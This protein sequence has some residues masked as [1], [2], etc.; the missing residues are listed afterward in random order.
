MIL[1]FFLGLHKQQC[2]GQ[3]H[4]RDLRDNFPMRLNPIPNAIS[5][6]PLRHRGKVALHLAFGQI[7]GRTVLIPSFL[8]LAAGPT[9]FPNTD[10]KEVPSGPPREQ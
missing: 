6:Q 3:N 8:T 1:N 4:H 5:G 7:L 9:V 2:E 10:L